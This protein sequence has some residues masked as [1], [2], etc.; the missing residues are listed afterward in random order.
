MPK[1]EPSL[2]AQDES[3]KD[4]LGLDSAHVDEMPEPS[5]L[6][7]VM[8]Y[9]KRE[10]D[11]LS[12]R[13]EKKRLGIEGE[14]PMLDEVM[15]DAQREG[16]AL[17]DN[18]E[19]N[20]RAA[21]IKRLMKVDRN[22]LRELRESGE[23]DEMSLH[24]INQLGIETGLEK[25]RLTGERNEAAAR[26]AA[27]RDMG[28][29]KTPDDKYRDRGD[30]AEE[31][32]RA[33]VDVINQLNGRK[34][35]WFSKIKFNGKIGGFDGSMR[36]LE[37]KNELKAE[38]YF[39]KKNDEE[40]LSLLDEYDRLLGEFRAHSHDLTSGGEVDRIGVASAEQFD[41]G[42]NEG[43]EAYRDEAFDDAAFD[44]APATIPEM[45]AVI[46]EETPTVR[47]MPS[48]E[49]ELSDADIVEETPTVQEMPRAET[50]P[51]V[52]V[53]ETP[54]LAD[55]EPANSRFETAEAEMEFATSETLAAVPTEAVTERDMEAAKLPKATEEYVDYAAVERGAKKRDKEAGAQAAERA[56][57]SI[58]RE[59]QYLINS[60]PM[61]EDAKKMLMNDT[62]FAH[63][64]QDHKDAAG[65]VDLASVVSEYQDYL[66]EWFDF[67]GL[68]NSRGKL[69]GSAVRNAIKEGI[70]RERIDAQYKLLVQMDDLLDYAT[71]NSV[72]VAN[73]PGAS[74]GRRVAAVQRRAAEVSPPPFDPPTEIPAREIPPPLPGQKETV[75]SME[76]ADEDLHEVLSTDE[77]IDLIDSLAVGE[78]NKIALYDRRFMDAVT[79]ANGDVLSASGAALAEVEGNLEALGVK[80]SKD[81]TIDGRSARKFADTDDYK[82][83]A[84]LKELQQSMLHSRSPGKAEEMRGRF[85]AG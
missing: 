23:L 57:Q 25:D 3:K 34:I 28:F 32:W 49:G 12:R 63:R 50:L 19:S 26:Y 45:P 31:K 65:N 15:A 5:A 8:E 66:D 21:A 44:A 64:V 4:F 83:Y 81:G 2:P 20:N 54:T 69:R 33:L 71:G 38:A 40:G 37:M 18:I 35:G 10:G 7:E 42:K 36:G 16:D 27:A 53:D 74:G 22:L 52:P 75:E 13:H 78:E 6:D 79:D 1:S 61:D 17:S 68:L 51:Y 67:H 30:M 47:E 77:V 76:V 80:F 72:S 70:S 48:L 43:A 62:Y 9:G 82:L 58:R 46:A 55:V 41:I 59:S 39:E 73:M 29:H 84:A 24:E 56:Y 11:A 60:I 85:N 14:T